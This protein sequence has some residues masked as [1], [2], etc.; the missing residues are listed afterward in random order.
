MELSSADTRQLHAEIQQLYT[1]HDLD[2]FG[3]NALTIVDRS[4]DRFV[5]SDIP[6]FH[7]NSLRTR[8]I[9]TIFLPDFLGF[10]PAMERITQ[11]Y[12]EEHPI[13]QRMPRTLDG[14]YRTHLRSF[15]RSPRIKTE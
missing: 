6:Q 10:T 5:P 11:Q 12:F 2:T 4:I 14:V 9:S 15:E 8:Q 1:L 3:V 13:A 7:L